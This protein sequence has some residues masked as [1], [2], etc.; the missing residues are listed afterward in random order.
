MEL[1]E[2]SAILNVVDYFIWG[3]PVL[4]IVVLLP[5]TIYDQ[6]KAEYKGFLSPW[7]ILWLVS[8]AATGWSFPSHRGLNP[9]SMRSFPLCSQLRP[10]AFWLRRCTE[11]FTANGCT[12][13]ESGC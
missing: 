11:G 5:M 3:I 2:L 10:H 7:A 6:K 8:S 13:E 12:S 4:L 1:P 9:G